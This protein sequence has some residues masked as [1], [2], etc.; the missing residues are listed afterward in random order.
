MITGF[1]IRSGVRE[2]PVFEEL[3][4]SGAIVKAPLVE[5][6]RH[7]GREVA[8]TALLRTSQQVCFYILHDLRHHLRDDGARIRPR[9]RAEHGDDDGARVV[10]R[11]PAVRA[12]VGHVR[13][14][15]DHRDRAARS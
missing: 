13:P 15:D 1:Y 14:P 6:L 2:T 8:L 12:P 5:V 3:K 7:N 11:Q 10:L 4:K 9:A